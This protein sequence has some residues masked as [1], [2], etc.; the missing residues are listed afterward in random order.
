MF[1]GM[2]V[3]YS[4]VFAALAAVVYGREKSGYYI[5]A[6]I[7]NSLAFLAVFAFAVVQ[8]GKR[9]TLPQ[10]LPAFF[11]CFAGDIFMALYN[12]S[13]R[14]RYFL[15][16]LFVFLIGHLC[17]VGWLCGMQTLTWG[18]VLAAL[19]AVAGAYGL[20]MLPDM[21]TGR[22]KPF[23]LIYA[24]FVALFFFKGL[25]L[26][27]AFPLPSSCFAAAGSAL[28]FVSDISILFLYFWKKKSKAVHLFNLGTYYYGMFFLASCLLFE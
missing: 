7:L 8:S 19:C 13:R 25:R 22:L 4:V 6:K 21:K 1:W 12:R 3:T 10:M 14:K 18:D 5:G 15:V 28:F 16:G 27:L 2:L 20:C 17:F 9:E 11:C 24:F 26:A 23:I